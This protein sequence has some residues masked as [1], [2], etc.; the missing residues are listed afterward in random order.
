[1]ADEDWKALV[2]LQEP[3]ND[4]VNY[5]TR[6][7]KEFFNKIFLKT[8]DLEEC[9][10]PAVYYLIGEKG[11]GKT[12]YA[13]YL[14]NNDVDQT[15]CKL[16][17]MTESQYKRFIAMKR[18]GKLEYSD[19]ANIWRPMLL[20]MMSQA[21][22]TKSKGILES[23]TGKFN[24]IE[25]E[26]AKF[27]AE[28][29]NPEVEVAFE[30]VNEESLSGAL[31]ND[32]IGKVG[33]EVKSKETDKTE[34]IKHHL[35]AV[36]GR[37]KV[38]IADLRLKRNHVLFV[39]GIDYRPEFVPYADYLAC[40]KGM[41]EAVWQLNTEFFG[42]IRDSQGRIKIVL[43]VRPDVF[44]ALNLYNS[45]SRLQDN[46]VFLDWST[47]EAALQES[48]LYKATGKFFSSQQSN[49]STNPV[50][51]A[52]HYLSAQDSNFLFKRLLRTSY[53]KPRDLLTFIRI[54]RK[55]CIKRLGRG[56]DTKFL[57]DIA[58]NPD[59][60]R[61][62]SDYL[63]GEVRNYSAFYMGQQDFALY[64]KFFQ[65]L[66]GKSEFT[67][68]DFIRAFDRFKA[69][70]RGEEIKATEYVRDPEALLQFFYD[71]N[72][73]GYRENMGAD[74]ERF[75]HFSFRERSLNNLAPKVKTSGFLMVGPGVAK[76]LDIGL[77]AKGASV[78]EIPARRRKS[79]RVSRPGHAA[80]AHAS[81]RSSPPVQPKTEPRRGAAGKT[82]ASKARG[83]KRSG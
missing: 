58:K 21:L 6:P 67:F 75:F 64:I 69:W 10:K 66:D 72:L 71:V 12:A 62:Y 56:G 7:Q 20:N 24:V 78:G 8:E 5:R 65:Y 11:S 2:D 37:L 63:L 43:L 33:A 19:Y 17:T 25:E 36:E 60:T 41:G 50:D 26:I 42:N 35:L 3:F 52:N 68:D 13:A 45:N 74:D 49:I 18:E 76:A 39:D 70:I 48:S 73:V 1:M 14:E 55:I 40:I 44:H 34:R 82:P 31:G 46:S 79:R 83:G 16:S 4:A 57:S 22:V 27:N 38:A 51:A 54:A 9:L 29:L 23:F 80:A 53:H 61:E 81:T 47:T 30:M 15:R 28:A 59:F 77:R 32:K